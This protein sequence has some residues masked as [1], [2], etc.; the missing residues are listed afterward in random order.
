M[1]ERVSEAPREDR[2]AERLEPR[3][4]DTE[5]RTGIVHPTG[6]PISHSTNSGFSRSRGREVW[7]EG[8]D[9]SPELMLLG[10]WRPSREFVG[11]FIDGAPPSFQSRA[12]G[13]AHICDAIVS[14]VPAP[15]PL[16]PVS[17]SRR[18]RRRSKLSG[19]SP[20]FVSDAVGVGHIDVIVSSTRV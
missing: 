5:P 14:G 19:V 18:R 7:S 16:M 3:N 15:L 13:V 17:C 8:D 4:A 20:S 6:R 12:V 10:A 11:T 2:V 9:A 1:P